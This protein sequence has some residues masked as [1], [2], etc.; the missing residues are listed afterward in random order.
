[1]NIEQF[2]REVISKMTDLEKLKGYFTADAVATGGVLPQPIPVTE[3]LKVTSGLFAGFPDF[4]I[5]IKQVLVSGNQATVKVEW[6][7]TQ[8]SMLS[9]PGFPPI[10]PTGKKVSVQDAY[11]LTVQG[12]KVSRFQIDT[13]AGGGIPG[14]LAQ[15]GVQLPAP[16]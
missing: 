13:P 8:T 3:S 12:D 10:P 9:L 4:K 5:D 15:L 11:I 2:A 14:A 16:R 6:S 7:G 1:M